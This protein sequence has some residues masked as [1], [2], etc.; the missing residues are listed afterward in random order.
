MA[1][2]RTIKDGTKLNLYVP[3]AVK[4]HLYKLAS[5]HRRSLSSMVVE[6]AMAT[7]LPVP[8]VKPQPVKEAA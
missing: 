2:P 7:P 3:L 6:M 4:R 1:R 8:A 5:H